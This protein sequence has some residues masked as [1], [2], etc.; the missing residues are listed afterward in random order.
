MISAR[1]V[2]REGGCMDLIQPGREAGVKKH[3]YI[4]C[5]GAPLLDMH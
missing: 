3:R 2:S 5:D 1:A 4:E